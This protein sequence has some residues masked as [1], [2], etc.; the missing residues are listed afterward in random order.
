MSD[1]A[2][3]WLDR[4]LEESKL[5]PAV[6]EA[7]LKSHSNLKNLEQEV[8]KD[9]EDLGKQKLTLSKDVEELKREKGEL[10][11]TLALIKENETKAV[12]SIL[13]RIH[14]KADGYLKDV[15]AETKKYEKRIAD[16]SRLEDE[17]NV[18]RLLTAVAFYPETAE[19]LP[20]DRAV[21]LLDAS[22][23]M[24]TAKGINPPVSIEAGRTIGPTRM[25][26]LDCMHL[27]RA[28]LLGYLASHR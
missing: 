21:M 17:L 23:R 16:T 18:A 20:L 8:R 26:L 27:C 7:E 4:M 19:K 11:Q 6:L 2:L 1:E 25:N 13:Q 9:T 14:D 28:T 5:D 24:C 15:S 22:E 3:L 10:T 12:E